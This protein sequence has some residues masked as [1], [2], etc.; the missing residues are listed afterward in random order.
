M[1]LRALAAIATIAL[2]G[3]ATVNSMAFDNKAKA[4]DLSKKSVVLMAFEVSRSDNSRHVPAPI[5][6][7]IE[8]P[9]A[10]EVKDRQNFRF[11]DGDAFQV[12]GR[13]VYLARMALEPG[14]WIVRG[15][16]GQANAFPFIGTWFV[17][18]HTAIT[19]KPNT[20]DYLGHVSAALRPRDE[21]AN[22]FRA[23]PVIPLIDQSV[24]GLSGGTWDVTVED[25][26]DKD[27]T[28][29]RSH[30]GALANATINPAVMPP[31]DRAVAQRFWASDGKDATA[32]VR[33]AAPAP[34]AAAEPAA[35]A[36]PAAPAEAAAQPAAGA[37]H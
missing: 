29:F 12:D 23:G 32:V 3:C 9:N 21:K 33:A 22:E 15:V 25:R 34:T 13:T 6:V 16:T 20:I 18:V 7:N 10:K 31:F 17:P 5:V 1:K 30:Y 28:L 11:G 37:D 4:V 26:N 2:T 24:A 27:Q 35:P 36:A 14:E 8:K 19:I